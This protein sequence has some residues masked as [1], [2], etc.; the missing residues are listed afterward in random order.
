MLRHEYVHYLMRAGGRKW[1]LW[2]DEGMAEYFGGVSEAR[3]RARGRRLRG[4]G[5]MGLDELMKVRRE[6]VEYS[7][8]DEAERFY[9]E[10]WALVDLLM[11]RCEGACGWAEVERWAQGDVG[12]RPRLER[13]L[14]RHAARL[15]GSEWSGGERVEARVRR[16][17]EG[18]VRVALAAVAVQIGELE[19]AR[20][21]L[22][23][24]VDSAEGWGLLGE[25]ELRQGRRSD[26]LLAYRE[27]MRL[28]SREKRVLWQLAVLEQSEGGDMVPALEKLVAADPGFDEARL[29]LSSHYLRQHRFEEALAQLRSVR[30]AAPRQA[31]YYQEALAAAEWGS[32]WSGGAQQGG[33][34]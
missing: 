3:A 26:A 1:P 5:W 2:L 10:S 25:L 15:R 12:E 34:E 17:G 33:L 23:E 8:A 28:G 32:G 29:V 9:G 4:R 6:S 14:R 22:R 27:A 21:L 16:L 19:R 18:E 31:P 20:A 24:G 11:R 13:A 7:R 30:Q